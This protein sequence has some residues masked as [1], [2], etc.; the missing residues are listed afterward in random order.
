M[1]LPNV[2][3]PSL[4]ALKAFAIARNVASTTGER[5]QALGLYRRALQLDPQFALAR[6]DMARLHASHGE[7][8]VALGEWRKALAIPQRLSPQEKLGVELM[9]LQYGASGP[10]FRKA[11]EYLALYP[12]DYRTMGRLATSHW[13]HRNDFRAGEALIRRTLVPQ[14]ERVAISHDALGTYLLGQEK[15][16]AALIE[17]RKARAAGWA[18]WAEYYARAFDVRGLHAEADKVYRAST[19]GRDGWKGR[20]R[21]HLI[22]VGRYDSMKASQPGLRSRMR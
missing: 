19:N 6:A 22:V 3:T 1:P 15:Y 12:D 9:L 20:G 10:Y 2:A 17:Y 13:H 16:D 14:Y 8:A 4:D 18:G 7:V 5:E 21:D 11:N